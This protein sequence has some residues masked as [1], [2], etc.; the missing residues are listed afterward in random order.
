VSLG[1]WSENPD[2]FATRLVVRF[3]S[4]TNLVVFPYD[5]P[6]EDPRDQQEPLSAEVEQDIMEISTKGI[7]FAS[8]LV[9]PLLSVVVAR[10]E[11]L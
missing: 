9:L 11:L 10:C 5:M 7:H 3:E 6:A 4:F 2:H 1:V 8:F